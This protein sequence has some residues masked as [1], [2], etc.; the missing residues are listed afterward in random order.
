MRPPTSI[1][2]TI[3][4]KLVSRLLRDFE[5]AWE[6]HFLEVADVTLETNPEFIQVAN[7]GDP[8][9]VAAFEVKLKHTQ[10]TRA[11]VLSPIDP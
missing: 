3:I 9:I 6:P 10:R 7:S 5:T 2:R 11:P 4:N 8:A 1:E